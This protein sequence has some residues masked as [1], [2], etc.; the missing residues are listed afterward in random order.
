MSEI[1]KKK[2]KKKGKN[3][4]KT[5]RFA[6]NHHGRGL[7]VM[8]GPKKDVDGHAAA[9]HAR[10]LSLIMVM[11]TASKHQR[12]DDGHQHDDDTHN[13]QKNDGNRRLSKD[14][15]IKQRPG[16]VRRV[17][18]QRQRN[19]RRGGELT[20]LRRIAYARARRTKRQGCKC[21][22]RARQARCRKGSRSARF[23]RRRHGRH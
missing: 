6:M 21:V 18:G 4:G 3:N 20:E 19:G 23:G 9:L 13:N 2:K 1:E 5:D 16:A 10:P 22:G 11:A 14:G 7:V 8:S 15:P 17:G 12:K